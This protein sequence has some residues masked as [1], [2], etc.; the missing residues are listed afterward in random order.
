MFLKELC[1]KK[2]IIN[3]IR[4][5][6]FLLI[7]LRKKYYK[8]LEK[9][10]ITGSHILK[11]NAY[12]RVA[13]NKKTTVLVFCWLRSLFLGTEIIIFS[14][15]WRV[16][17]LMLVK[18]KLLKFSRFFDSQVLKKT[19]GPTHLHQLRFYFK[20]LRRIWNSTRSYCYTISTI[21]DKIVNFL[22]NKVNKSERLL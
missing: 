14:C 7:L 22:R 12:L 16:H 21:F 19:F 18:T 8:R 1:P 6:K 5:S 3:C 10:Y 13:Y 11:I 2:S 17:Y 4:N 15:F 20:T 9:I